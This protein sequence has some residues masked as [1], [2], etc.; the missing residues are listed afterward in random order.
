[1]SHNGLFF[2]SLLVAAIGAVLKFGGITES[3][4]G[5]SLENIGLI[6][7]IVGVIGMLVGIMQMMSGRRSETLIDDGHRQERVVTRHSD[8]GL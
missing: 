2:G 1:M 6:L 3:G 4:E 8:P 5:F 7:L